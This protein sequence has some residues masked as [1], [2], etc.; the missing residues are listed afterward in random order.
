M[1]QEAEGR[2]QRSHWW[3][4]KRLRGKVRPSDPV[5]VLHPQVNP[6]PP[7]ITPPPNL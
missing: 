1:G 6:P 7:L 3:L 2:F 4:E 5:V